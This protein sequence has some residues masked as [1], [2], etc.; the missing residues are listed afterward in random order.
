M[1]KRLV[2]V[3]AALLLVTCGYLAAQGPIFEAPKKPEVTMPAT[4]SPST[5]EQLGFRVSRVHGNKAY[6]R[7]VAKVNGAWV[8]VELDSHNALIAH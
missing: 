4:S 5:V 7:L 2:L 6:G 8:D 3:S 1:R